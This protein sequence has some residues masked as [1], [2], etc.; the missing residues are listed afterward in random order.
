MPHAVDTS[1][2]CRLPA[3]CRAA[4][5]AKGLGSERPVPLAIDQKLPKDLRSAA[6]R[7]LSCLDHAVRWC[8]RRNHERPSLGSLEER[9][10]EDRHF[11]GGRIDRRVDVTVTEI[12]EGRSRRLRLGRVRGVWRRLAGCALRR[13]R[14]VT[15]N[16][17]PTR[18]RADRPLGSGLLGGQGAYAVLCC[19]ASTYSG[20]RSLQSRI[21]SSVRRP[22]TCLNLSGLCGMESV[23]YITGKSLG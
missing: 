17:L 5:A 6:R 2:A 14:P 16:P 12:D 21:D 11:S 3:W 10:D 13:K 22:R 18:R 15:T 8:L 19:T 7:R 20:I 9:R 1:R 4:L 23:S